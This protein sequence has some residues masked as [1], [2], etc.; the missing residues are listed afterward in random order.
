MEQTKEALSERRYDLVKAIAAGAAAN[1]G[2]Q[3]TAAAI[4]VFADALLAILYPPKE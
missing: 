2:T 3:T 4:V 1:S